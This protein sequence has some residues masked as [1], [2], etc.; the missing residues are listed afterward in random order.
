MNLQ[1]QCPK[2]SK[3]FTVHEDL[4]GKTVECGACDHRFPV[5][6][7]SIIVER[8]KFYPGE[9]KSEDFLNRLGKKWGDGEEMAPAPSA[10]TPQVDAIMPASAG[11]NIAA[12]AG[13]TFLILCGLIFFLGTSKGGMFQDV[14]MEKRLLLG[15]FVGLLSVGL[16]LFGSKNWRKRA[17]LFG[18]V[19]LAGLFALIF[20]RPVYTTPVV[21]DITEFQKGEDEVNEDPLN[22]DDIKSKVGYAAIERKIGQMSERFNEDGSEYVV[23]IFIEGLTGSQFVEVE[24]YLKDVLSIP[25]T[26]GVNLYKRNRERDSLVVVSGFKLDF[27][28][29]VRYCEPRLGRATSYPDLRLVDLKLSAS[30]FSKPSKDLQKILT[31]RTHPAYFSANLDELRSLT[32]A[33]VNNAVTR[34]STVADDEVELRHEEPII[35]EFLDL[36]V[37]K[38]NPVLLSDLGKAFRIWAG[39]NTACI[40]T[41]SR[42]V[43]KLLAEE[44]AIVPASLIDYLVE[45]DAEQAPLFVDRL[46]SLDPEKWVNQF[47]SM[48]PT[49]E[50]R[51]IFHLNDSPLRLKKASAILLE[52][53]GTDKA[54]PT[55]EKFRTSPDEEL[56]ILVERAIEAIKAR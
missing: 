27:D 24:N 44:G 50:P 51:I 34:L 2:C 30:L 10:P 4:T 41:V 28:T 11:Q 38:N 14:T 52:K 1:I 32:P 12:A 53:I 49:I 21:D 35:K 19:L 48:G 36:L 47:A 25:P 8:S 15:G 22:E 29:V 23:G 31:D 5:K 17:T 26:E 20:I 39:G 9:H 54:L 55:L 13:A 43:S 7:E 56:K 37:T 40:D 3:R 42:K 16:I 18:I 46:W 33:R 6:S 45:N